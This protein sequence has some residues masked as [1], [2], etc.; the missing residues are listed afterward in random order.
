MLKN[1]IIFQLMLSGLQAQE[2]T[3]RSYQDGKLAFHSE[4]QIRG[5]NNHV[6]TVRRSGMWKAMVN[7]GA[8]ACVRARMCVQVRVHRVEG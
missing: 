5:T 6:R 2:T 1:V 8:C 7:R 3:G 4:A